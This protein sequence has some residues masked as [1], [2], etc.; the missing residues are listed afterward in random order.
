M[1]RLFSAF[2]CLSLL[3]SVATAYTAP[4]RHW[5]RTQTLRREDGQNNYNFSDSISSL[6]RYVA[7]GSATSYRGLG[8]VSIR[9]D[10]G[11]G[12]Q[13]LIAL[14]SP[15]ASPQITDRFGQQVLLFNYQGF[16]QVAVAATGTNN[17]MGMI[18]VFQQNVSNATLWP[19]TQTLVPPTGT[20][21]TNFGRQMLYDG[22]QLIV[23]AERV[24]KSGQRFR[25]TSI[26]VVGTAKFIQSDGIEAT[27]PGDPLLIYRSVQ[28]R[29]NLTY[30]SYYETISDATYAYNTGGSLAIS[31]DTMVVG[32]SFREPLKY[33]SGTDGD[34]EVRGLTFLDGSATFNFNNV[35]IREGGT[36]TIEHYDKIRGQGGWLNLKIKNLL[37]IEKGGLINLTAAGYSGGATAFTSGKAPEN[38]AFM[39]GGEAARSQY[40][41]VF[42]CD[43]SSTVVTGIQVRGNFATVGRGQVNSS[44]PFAEACG[45]GGSYGTKGT[46]GTKVACGDSG[47]PGPIYG[48]P[49]LS[50]LY[51]GSGGGS[52]FPWRVGAG[53]A[54]G[55]G[56]GVVQINAKRII[57]YGMIA[58]NGADGSDGGFFSGA[59]G[60]GSGGSILLI[61][62]NLA[63]Y[64]FIYAKGGHGGVRASG[65]GSGGDF[66]VKGGDGGYGRIKFDVL[67][68]QAHGH[69]LPRPV[70]IT[71]YLGDVL[72]YKRNATT[73][74]WRLRTYLPRIP[75]FQFIGHSVALFGNQLAVSSQQG[76]P[77]DPKQQV[78]LIDITNVVND[79]SPYPYATLDPPVATDAAFGN[80][81]VW[82][83][84]SLA[85]SA[86][87]SPAVRGVVYLYTSPNLLSHAS[88]I[89]PL[90]F[91]SKQPLPGDAF[92]EKFLLEVPNFYIT[93][94]LSQD[95][96]L[97]ASVRRSLGCVALYKF[98]RNI[99]LAH[100]KVTCEYAS[101]TANVTLNCTA[102]MF[103]ADG[104]VAGDLVDLQFFHPAVDFRS[105]GVYTFQTNFHDA[106][107][108]P[109]MLSYLHQRITAPTITVTK[110]IDPLWSNVTCTPMTALAGNQPVVC[111]I[112]TQRDS[113]EEIAAKEF[114]VIVWCLDDEI[115][116]VEGTV[117]WT[118]F[119]QFRTPP[120]DTVPTFTNDTD[121]TT[122]EPKVT[123]FSHGHYRF[124]F[125]PWK[126]GTFGVFVMYKRAALRFPNPVLIDAV[127]APVSFTNSYVLCPAVAR[128]NRTLECT[129][130]L[131]ENIKNS[132]T[133]LPNL[134]AQLS[135]PNV[136]AAG[137]TL[138]S[139]MVQLLN[140]SGVYAEEGRYSVLTYPNATGFVHVNIT[141]GGQRVPMVPAIG[142][143]I[144][145]THP[146]ACL[147][148]ARIGNSFTI[149][150][151]AA[152]G[153]SDQRL[154]GISAT[155]AKYS[156]GVGFCDNW[157]V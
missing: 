59:G 14:R 13:Q 149:T 67:Q 141:L 70:N 110:H 98:A 95:E 43:Y 41:G 44:L 29:R 100:S 49:L 108:H 31:G 32:S 22:I 155:I 96:A 130:Y 107:K 6:G 19:L 137:Y 20:Y 24:Y 4:Q 34:L 72:I 140:V 75:A 138:S 21:V 30:L 26:N 104:Q 84:H 119:G 146:V 91:T 39:G 69:V 64:G 60:G 74:Q 109:V 25:V 114:D 66:G 53:G 68:T 52:G 79:T 80:R 15:S 103:A 117:G 10:K 92:G 87:G 81:M 23:S 56:G 156:N 33:G 116:G 106:G 86:A 134:A 51:R 27:I 73:K 58:A 127:A 113:G 136:T 55:N 147:P 83:N 99:S 102:H 135:W 61:S 145:N 62:D 35:Y 47:Q 18:Y 126:P 111:T 85:I 37:L 1:E 82:H 105:I 42:A 63:N 40:T 148:F 112:T 50:V 38:G 88:T 28:D 5:I 54:G 142:V 7:I 65:S 46:A 123:F 132:P 125:N 144:T 89:T 120:A 118:P 16:T 77:I 78:F 139:S 101:V 122:I 150:S 93:L 3:L 45:G 143:N 128:P 131:R 153:R 71:T 2:A 76:T 36:L 9:Y 11:D 154:Y 151:Q 124:E 115:A 94:P 97:P 129:L 57:N 12:L 90:V 17:G 48:E 133:T 121:Y 157:N 152:Q 8:E